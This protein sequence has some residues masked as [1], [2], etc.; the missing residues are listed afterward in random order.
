MPGWHKIF[1]Y[2][3]IDWRH[4]SWGEVLIDD[5]TRYIIDTACNCIPTAKNP[6]VSSAKD[7]AWLK[8]EDIAFGITVNRQPRAYPRR[9]IELRE[10]VNNTLGGRYLGLAYGT[11]CG[12]AQAYFTD[13]LPPSINPPVL[14]TSRLLIHSN[15]VIYDITSHSVFDTF[16]CKAGTRPIAKKKIQLKQ[17]S[18]VTTDSDPSTGYRVNVKVQCEN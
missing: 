15:K 4:T 17:V 14:R 16:P 5:R 11:L 18:V 9:I 13:Q 12:A 6:K 3:E 8:D 7:S 2:G 10:M 1:V